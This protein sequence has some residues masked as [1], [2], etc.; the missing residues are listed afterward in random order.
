M[1]KG[2]ALVL[3]APSGTG[4]TTLCNRLLAEF[5]NL[6][7]SISCTTRPQRPGE[8]DGK[9]YFFISPAEFAKKIEAGD[10]AEWAEVHGN[11]Y[12][13]PL[14]PVR[15]LLE[16]GRDVL[17]DIDVQGAGQLRPNLPEANFVFIFPPSLGELEK[18][19]LRRQLDSESVIKGRLANAASEIREAW[20]YDAIICNDCLERAYDQ[21]RSFYIAATLKPGLHSSMIETLLTEFQ[22]AKS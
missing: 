9:D 10:F 17:F 19:L 7:Y 11:L 16:E 14:A 12:G 5:P 1:R 8:I 2:I 6:G 18:R 4:K 13:S 3:S 22:S 21:L 20:L 15:K